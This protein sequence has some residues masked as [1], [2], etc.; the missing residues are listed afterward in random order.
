MTRYELLHLTRPT[1]NTM[2]YSWFDLLEGHLGDIERACTYE[3]IVAFGIL[4]E[5]FA[6]YWYLIDSDGS[7]YIGN[8]I[9]EYKSKLVRDQ[10]GSWRVFTPSIRRRK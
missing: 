5:Q 9:C 10:N 4:V 8:R 3:D 2:L 1:C 6:V 7:E